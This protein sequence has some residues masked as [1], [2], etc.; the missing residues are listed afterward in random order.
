MLDFTFEVDHRVALYRGGTNE[1]DNLEALCPG[2]HRR[3]TVFEGRQENER[4]IAEKRTEVYRAQ[5][6]QYFQPF[7]GEAVPLELVRDVMAAHC[8]WPASES[9]ARLEALGHHSSPDHMHFPLVMWKSLW[10]LAKRA[11]PPPESGAPVHGL[12]VRSGAIHFMRASD[13][14]KARREEAASNRRLQDQMVRERVAARRHAAPPS[15]GRGDGIKQDATAAAAWRSW[16]E[17]RQALAARARHGRA[18]GGHA[19]MRA[20]K[21]APTPVLLGRRV[22]RGG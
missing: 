18:A 5:L 4:K 22:L 2:C 14:T 16:R 15:P 12:R 13:D 7:P 20:C 9:D 6:Y 1:L 3:K 19:G 11:T 8:G 17:I 21:R 10:A